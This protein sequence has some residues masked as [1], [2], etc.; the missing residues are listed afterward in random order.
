MTVSNCILCGS[1]AEPFIKTLM[2]EMHQCSICGLVYAVPM[3]LPN[4]PEVF[5]T[6]IHSGKLQEPTLNDLPIRLSMLKSCKKLSTGDFVYRGAHLEAVTWI[7][8]NAPPGSTIL[9]IGCGTGAFL[10]A[11]QKQGFHGVGVEPSLDIVEVLRTKGLEVYR[12]TINDIPSECPKSPFGIA[13]LFL[14][15]HLVDPVAAIIS[16]R[17]KYP[18]SYLLVAVNDF[19]F[20][21]ER[22]KRLVPQVLPPRHLTWWGPKS[23]RLLLSK[24]GYEVDIVNCARTPHEYGFLSVNASVRLYDALKGW[25]PA[26]SIYLLHNRFKR[27]LLWPLATIERLLRPRQTSLLAIA[28]PR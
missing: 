17:M 7:K 18:E 14:I 13:C 4:C 12:G 24:A 21:K 27:F 8:R 1:Q 3:Q 26:D 6:E 11:L 20:F 22:I 10:I 28:R 23:L 25:L 2:V 19:S 15:H 5:F 16:L 9:D